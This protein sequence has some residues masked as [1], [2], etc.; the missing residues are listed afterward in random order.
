MFSFRSSSFQAAFLNFILDCIPVS[1]LS[2]TTFQH[3]NTA[4][5]F[6]LIALLCAYPSVFLTVRRRPYFSSLF[7]QS[8]HRVW[9]LTAF[10]IT[11][12][13]ISKKH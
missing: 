8:L 6:D 12:T 2:L 5:S 13:L 10:T 1:E 7:A 3:P 4:F 11:K 9:Y